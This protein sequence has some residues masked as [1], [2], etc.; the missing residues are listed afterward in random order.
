MVGAVTA[1]VICLETTVLDTPVNYFASAL[2]WLGFVSLG[3][4][5]LLQNCVHLLATALVFVTFVRLVE[6]SPWSSLGIRRRSLSDIF[7]GLGVGLADSFFFAYP[8]S[9]FAPL[10]PDTNLYSS[11][12]V[13]ELWYL[14]LNTSDAILEEVATRAYIFEKM[15]DFTGSYFVAAVASLSL[16]VALH[17]PRRDLNEF[18]AIVPSLLLL[19]VLYG[20]CRRALPRVIAHVVMNT[21]LWLAALNDFKWLV[22]SLMRPGRLSLMIAGLMIV[23]LTLRWSLKAV[24]FLFAWLK[25]SSLS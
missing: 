13:Q 3:S 24:L 14:A 15:L 8:F 2:F 7:L 1:M 10:R 20:Y 19:A 18:I 23:Y 16:S 21:L 9:A 4:F 22:V 11:I 25:Q 5:F 6:K 12:L 17:I